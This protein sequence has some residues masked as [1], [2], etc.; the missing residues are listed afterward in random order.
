MV[1]EVTVCGVDDVVIMIFHIVLTY[2]THKRL[3][4]TFKQLKF[5]GNNKTIFSI[6]LS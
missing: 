6:L 1:K 3:K 4:E 5:V 2:Q